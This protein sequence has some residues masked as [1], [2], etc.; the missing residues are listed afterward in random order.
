MILYKDKNNFFCIFMNILYFD[1]YN[2]NGVC[3]KSSTPHNSLQM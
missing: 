3:N 1:Y 2:I